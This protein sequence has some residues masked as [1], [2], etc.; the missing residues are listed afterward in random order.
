[1]VNSGTSTTSPA[2]A[3][4]APAHTPA[5]A[6]IGTSFVTS[7]GFGNTYRVTLNRV[8]DPAQ[9]VNTTPVAGDRTVGAVYTITPVS[10]S[11]RGENA[12]TNA[13]LLGANG[14]VYRA[15][16][17]QVAGYGNFSN[18]DISVAPGSSTTGAIT[19]QVPDGVRIS[20]THW[21][22]HAGRGTINRWAVP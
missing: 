3:A 4:P 16:T 14:H 13:S 21:A 22:A 6:P 20:E 1:V 12:I 18:Y 5:P 8:I 11:P 19:Y 17:G 2:H 7:D 9:G 15:N 10:G